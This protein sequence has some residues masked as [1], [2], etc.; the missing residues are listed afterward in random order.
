MT[1]GRTRRERH[2]PRSPDIDKPIQKIM[3]HMGRAA[4]VS[5]LC[6]NFIE[7]GDEA[8]WVDESV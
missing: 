2:G 7:D 5:G 8:C 4:V 6:N 1:M 3:K